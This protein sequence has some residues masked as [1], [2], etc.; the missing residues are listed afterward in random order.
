MLDQY[1][2]NLPSSTYNNIR[3]SVA[4]NTPPMYQDEIDDVTNQLTT[5]IRYLL[6]MAV[7]VLFI[8]LF[9]IFSEFINKLLLKT[10]NSFFRKKEYH[11]CTENTWILEF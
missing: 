5:N 6:G 8:F 7:R 3:N 10:F 9:I 2:P 11:R 1:M 4:L